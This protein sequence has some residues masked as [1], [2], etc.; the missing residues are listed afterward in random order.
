MF[1]KTAENC[2]GW[3]RQ[4]AEKKNVIICDNPASRGEAMEL[5]GQVFEELNDRIAQVKV[6]AEDVSLQN[7]VGVH[8]HRNQG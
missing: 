3:A 5:F 1:G 4:M 8:C 7:F 6:K 2:P